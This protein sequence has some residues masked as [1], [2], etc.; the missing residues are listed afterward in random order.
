MS[1]DFGPL[2]A[3]MA[4]NS[5]DR[6]T[7]FVNE[8]FHT[9]GFGEDDFDISVLNFPAVSNNITHH[10][11]TTQHF[12]QQQTLTHPLL[13]S[14]NIVYGQNSPTTVSC[15][16]LNTMETD[17]APKF[18]PQNFDVPDISITNS[19]NST[20]DSVSCSVP[21]LYTMNG[22]HMDSMTSSNRLTTI[23]HSEVSEQL[24]FQSATKI[25]SPDS[26][27][28]T[29]SP[30]RESSE[31]SDDS[32]PLA[33]LALLKR[34]AEA[35]VIEETTPDVSTTTTT[36]KAK[37]TPKKKKKKDP[38]E[39]QKPVSA[40]ALF[41][42]DTQAA[43]KGQN[44]SATF[45]EVSKIV[46]SMWDGLDP[47]HKSVYKKK[48]ENAKKEYL[49]Q[50]AAYRASLV[51]QAAIED[52]SVL[53]DKPLMSRPIK[54][55]NLHQ[56]PP[57]GNM[58]PQMADNLGMMGHITM[59]T[60]SPPHATSPLHHP[61]PPNHNMG[62]TSPPQQYTQ[63]NLVSIAPRPGMGHEMDGDM[64]C[65]MMP[66]M[67]VRMECTNPAIESPGWDNEYCSNEC[68]VSHCRDVFT[69]WVSTRQGSNSFQVK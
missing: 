7:N 35:P 24:G 31:D 60:S 55:M 36:G 51:S 46:A 40:Y 39:P 8:T 56:S 18:P 22:G 12:S 59:N 21:S 58:S 64:D 37:K 33:Q 49:K 47:E 26:S 45:G 62:Y 14:M 50:M 13:G 65:N 57:Q 28:S 25:N 27:N 63:S 42:R 5:A 6:G 54:Q 1:P 17:V 16:P 15:V 61:S 9:P 10:T 69:A 20:S 11:D 44:P 23:S 29:T 68:V 67:C 52:G 4:E 3:V 43:I 19:L 2:S 53:S 32:L 38:N 41:F 66:T 48:T 34:Q 30:S